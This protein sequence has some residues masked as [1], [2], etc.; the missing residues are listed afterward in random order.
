MQLW[1]SLY[2]QAHTHIT[3]HS[4]SQCLFLCIHNY[5]VHQCYQATVVH[6]V[7]SSIGPRWQS[8]HYLCDKNTMVGE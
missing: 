4:P 2:T 8:L 3:L 6:V 1:D 7:Y 5:R